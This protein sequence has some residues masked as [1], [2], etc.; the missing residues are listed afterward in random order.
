M[1]PGALGGLGE[2]GDQWE[3]YRISMGFHGISWGLIN[4]NSES[5]MV[6]SWDLSKKNGDLYC[7]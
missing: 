5:Q 6:I 1:A 7:I 2:P 4:G 3:C